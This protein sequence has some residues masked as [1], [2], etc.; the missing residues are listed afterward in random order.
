[1]QAQQQPKGASSKTPN[2]EIVAQQ[3]FGYNY[4]AQKI[5]V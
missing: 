5:L 2:I 4:N 3:D 1:L